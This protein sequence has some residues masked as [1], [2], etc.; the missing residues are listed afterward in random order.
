MYVKFKDKENDDV[1]L[2]FKKKVDYANGN[3]VLIIPKYK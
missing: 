1:Y 2:T 3:H